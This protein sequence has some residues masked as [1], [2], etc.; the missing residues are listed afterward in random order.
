M[1]LVIVHH[2]LNVFVHLANKRGFTKKMKT[3]RITVVVTEIQTEPQVNKSPALQYVH[4][5]L[6]VLLLS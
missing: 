3:L 4:C 2:L 1:P 6:G 5:I